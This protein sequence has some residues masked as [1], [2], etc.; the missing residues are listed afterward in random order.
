MSVYWNNCPKTKHIYFRWRKEEGAETGGR[1][2]GLM[3]INVTLWIIC[4][5]K[6]Y[7][8]D[9]SEIY[10]ALGYLYLFISFAMD[11]PWH[12]QHQFK[13]SWPAQGNASTFIRNA[14]VILKMQFINPRQWTVFFIL[15][16]KINV[17]EL[18]GC[19]RWLPSRS[20]GA[21]EHSSNLCRQ[22]HPDQGK[23]IPKHITQC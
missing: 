5:Y 20:R 22:H 8:T 2:L 3:M 4:F 6:N 9:Q 7:L 16:W 19:Q 23:K 12:S 18:E 15:L 11:V 14:K 21:E 10:E 1:A 13:H 17:I